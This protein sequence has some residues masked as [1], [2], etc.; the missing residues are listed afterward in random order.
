MR[1]AA[2][3]VGIELR[4]MYLGECRDVT[5]V[6]QGKLFLPLLVNRSSYCITVSQTAS[7]CNEPMLPQT[8]GTTVQHADIPLSREPH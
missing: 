4:V 3:N 7:D 1:S 5:H 6:S 2:C 8:I